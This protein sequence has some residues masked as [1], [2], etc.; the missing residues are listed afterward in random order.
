M[1]K[2][3]INPSMREVMENGSRQ[4]AVTGDGYIVEAASKRKLFDIIEKKSYSFLNNDDATRIGKTILVHTISVK[5]PNTMRTGTIGGE[6]CSALFKKYQK[7]MN[8]RTQSIHPQPKCIADIEHK[9]KGSTY[10]AQCQICG[11][12]FQ[13]EFQ[14]KI[15]IYTYTN[16]PKNWWNT[17][18]IST[19]MNDPES[20]KSLVQT[21]LMRY[22]EKHHRKQAADT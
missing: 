5:V 7:T 16:R 14:D 13:L 18:K 12:R 11:I 15:P 21:L 19:I 20:K 3:V 17:G 2:Y 8:I 9:Y 10:G 4:L 1:K 22:S 6:Q